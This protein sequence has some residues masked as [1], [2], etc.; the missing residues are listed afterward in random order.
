MLSKYLR[1]PSELELISASQFSKVYT[2][3]GI[4]V[5]KDDD[6]DKES[7]PEDAEIVNTDEDN[8]KVL[9]EYVISG[10]HIHQRLPKYIELQNAMPREQKLMR[11]RKKPAV[12]R[13]HKSNKD[14]NFESWMLKELM[15]YTHYRK[16]DLES[17]ES[18]TAEIY[19]QRQQWIQNVKS[20]VMEQ[21]ECVEEARLMVEQSNKE[22]ISS[23][24][25]YEINAA[26]EQE[27]LDCFLEGITEHQD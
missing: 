16:T 2:T 21:L 19:G 14:N 5:K 10:S 22:A 1:R 3:S 11:K 15:L 27:N 12:L 8:N 23:E 4:K 9:V 24:I 18:K 17:F 13:Y 25:G 20:K 26:N 6:D 7:E